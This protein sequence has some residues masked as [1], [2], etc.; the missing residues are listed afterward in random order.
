MQG[1]P[2]R[3]DAFEPFLETLTE[4]RSLPPLTLREVAGTPIGV[5]TESLL[6]SDGQSW[7]SLLLLSGLDSS[8]EF[9]DWWNQQSPANAGFLDL[10]QVSDDMLAQFRDSA[11]ERLA[12]GILAILLILAVGLRSAR[13]AFLTLLPV[14]VATGLTAALLGGIGERLS[15]FHLIAMLLTAGIGIDYSLFFQRKE[16]G[17]PERLATL[18]A[19]LVCAVSTVTV[20]GILAT[21]PIPVLRAIGITVAI[22]VPW[23]FLLSLVSARPGDPGSGRYQ[24]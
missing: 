6:F 14:L 22:G 17:V 8:S 23:C 24:T 20:F 4:S 11:L 18:H 10:K 7:K 21:S 9:L 15:L 12:L 2:F 13:R 1:L 19:L 16:S 3:Q 5:R